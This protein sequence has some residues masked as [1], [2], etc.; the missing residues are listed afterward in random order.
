MIAAA[1]QK[2]V[3]WWQNLSFNWF[4]IALLG[5]LAFGFWRGRKRGMSREAV[6]TIMWLAAVIGAGYGY[7]PLGEILQKTGYVK[8]VIG[9]SFNDR[10]VSFMIAYVAICLVALIIYSF[11]AK[12]FREKVSGSNTF[13]NGEY[14]LG[15]V[16]GMIRYA[17]IAMFFLALLN[18]PYYSAKEIA[19]DKAYKNRWYGGGEKG[20][21][22]DYIPSLADIQAGVFRKSLTGPFIKD[23]LAVF[24]VGG[25]VQLLKASD[26][27]HR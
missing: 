8:Q 1:V 16:S 27:I 17:C 12:I 20:Y 9:R 21:S 10:T 7:Q 26:G 25:T 3:P 23:Q 2:T 15:M 14:Y 22:G 11:L 4:D 18:A 5:V 6:P 19:D 13:G 24:L